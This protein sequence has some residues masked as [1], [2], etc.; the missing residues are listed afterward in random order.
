MAMAVLNGSN[1]WAPMLPRA[2]VYP[3]PSLLQRCQKDAKATEVKIYSKGGVAVGGGMKGVGG[4]GLRLDMGM[5]VA[6]RRLVRVKCSGDSVQRVVEGNSSNVSNSTINIK[7]S[8]ELLD[9]W[10]KEPAIRSGK[11]AES[12]AVRRLVL[13]DALPKKGANFFF[14]PTKDVVKILGFFLAFNFN[15]EVLGRGFGNFCGGG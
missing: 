15:F 5:M 10:A 4:H 1:T 2:G 14:F 11:N 3:A 7:P 13:W 9:R 12:E 8:E 6:E